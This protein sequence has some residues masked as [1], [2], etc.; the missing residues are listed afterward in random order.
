ML[1]Y[2]LALVEDDAIL[3]D[4]LVSYFA[5]QPEFSCMCAAGS[6]EELLTWLP[7]AVA[8][9]QLI[10]LDLQL[11]GL[12]GLQALPLL[13]QLAPQADVVVQ[14]V[15]EDADRL[16][17]ALRQGASGYLVKSASLPALKAALL[18]VMQGGAPLSRAVARKVLAYFSP[19][20]L[21]PAADVLTP[22][23]REVVQGL[24]EGLG[25]KQLAARLGI[26]VHTVHTY[27]KRLY[28]KLHVNSRAELLRRIG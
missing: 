27:V 21:A 11:P 25:E 19:A 8:P 3:R 24:G 18:E 7:D 9:P 2:R 22:R 20:P 14:T 16:F 10:L 12:S 5:Q 15:F 4:I 23:E 1:P 17:E 28:R 26:T 13:R 6:A